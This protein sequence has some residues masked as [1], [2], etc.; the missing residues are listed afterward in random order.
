[1]NVPSSAMVQHH[2]KMAYSYLTDARTQTDVDISAE[3]ISKS[4]IDSLTRAAEH[5]VKAREID[6][7]AVYW[8][9]DKP[10]EEKYKLS[11]NFLNAQVL[12]LEAV[13]HYNAAR[14]IGVKRSGTESA[15]RKNRRAGKA[16]LEQ[17]RIAGERALEYSSVDYNALN[18]LRHVYE[19]LGD[20]DNLR[21]VVTK[22]MELRPDDLDIHKEFDS[23]SDPRWFPDPLFDNPT[24]IGRLFD[25]PLRYPSLA[26][27]ISFV[28]LVIGSASSII[29]KIGIGLVVISAIWWMLVRA[30]TKIE[31][32]E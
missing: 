29:A 20:R 1:M 4:T 9:A 21:R 24:L 32:P 31:V 10:G 13:A 23:V 17:A 3:F 15:A 5:L 26:V 19:D 6:P 16:E 27:G 11:Q 14:A 22:L 2:L 8:V 12:A 18:C 28:I 7:L 30:Y 25:L